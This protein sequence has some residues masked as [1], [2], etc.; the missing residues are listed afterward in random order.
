[1]PTCSLSP[2]AAEVGLLLVPSIP[3]APHPVSTAKKLHRSPKLGAVAALLTEKGWWA[4]VSR[5]LLVMSS[6]GLL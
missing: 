3:L 1:M 4:L 2:N 5:R 6:N